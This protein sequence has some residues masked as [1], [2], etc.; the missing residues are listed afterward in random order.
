[1][2]SDGGSTILGYL[3]GNG[4]EERYCVDW[5]WKRMFDW[6]YELKIYEGNVKTVSIQLK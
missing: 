1:M 5:R 3:Y 2:D 4:L 6:T